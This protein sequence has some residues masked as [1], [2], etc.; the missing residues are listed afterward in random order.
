MLFNDNVTVTLADETTVVK[1]ADVISSYNIDDISVGQ[2]LT[3]LGSPGDNTDLNLNADHV[4][5]LYTNIGGTVVSAGSL[6]V[7]GIS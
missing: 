2:R 1:Q 6:A 3:V 4:R 5:M 7:D